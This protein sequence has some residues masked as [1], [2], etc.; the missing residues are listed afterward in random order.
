MKSATYVSPDNTCWLGFYTLTDPLVYVHERIKLTQPQGKVCGCHNWIQVYN[1]ERLGRLDYRG[2]I[3]PKQR[4]RKFT[5]PLDHEQLVTIQFSWDREIKPVSTSLIGVSP[6]FELA[7]YTLC[8]LNGKEDN[9]LQLG[10]YLVNIK[11][12]SF[13]RGNNVKIGTAFPE[14]MPLTEAQAAVKIQALLRGKRARKQHTGGGSARPASSSSSTTTTTTTTTVAW[15]G[16]NSAA[17]IS[18]SKTTISTTTGGGGSAWGP[19]PGETNPTPSSAGPAPE[20]APEVT[21]AWAAP[22]KW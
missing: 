12:F 4:G 10:P 17:V 14:A 8:F 20:P 18:Q 6:E 1:E 16:G 7:L 13:G 3:R 9:V 11:C 5:E 19:K 15:G 21:G 2:H 22:H